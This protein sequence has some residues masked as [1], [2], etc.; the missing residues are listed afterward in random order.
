MWGFN[1][2]NNQPEPKMPSMERIAAILA[3]DKFKTHCKNFRNIELFKYLGLIER[4]ALLDIS[5]LT[6]NKDLLKQD[7]PR[8]V[9]TNEVLD[10]YAELD[11]I[12]PDI[13]LL[14]VAE[15]HMQYLTFEPNYSRLKK[16]ER[17]RSACGISHVPMPD[18]TVEV[19]REIFIYED[20]DFRTIFSG[21]HEFAHSMSDRFIKDVDFT[22]QAMAELVPSIVDVFALELYGKRHPEHAHIVAEAKK[23][24]LV[25]NV[26][27]ARQTLLEA[28]VIKVMLGETTFE[29]VLAKYGHIFGPAMVSDCVEDIEKGD[30]NPLFEAKY[31]LPHVMAETLI[32]MFKQNPEETIKN[33]KILLTCDTKLTIEQAY[34]VLKLPNPET[35][36]ANFNQKIVNNSLTK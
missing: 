12:C 4:V 34:D 20:G 36:L 2:E 14:P 13:P 22:S 27:K 21:P 10:F 15:K 6:V 31:V 35:T 29:E 25:S 17:P 18:G 5:K 16:G 33:I 1:M 3:N 26:L 11:K 32:E 19:L 8:E 9:I 7:Y 24:A 28:C 30:F 23:Q